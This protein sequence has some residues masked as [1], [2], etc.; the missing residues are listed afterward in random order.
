MAFAHGNTYTVAC[1]CYLLTKWISC[2]FRP[3][4]IV[5]DPEL[6]EIFCMLYAPIEVPSASTISYD[7]REIFS[8]SKSS[9]KQLLQVCDMFP[10]PM[11]A[12]GPGCIYK[13]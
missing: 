12:P 9:V 13:Y 7:I 2:R 1:M 5:E 8:M 4:M 11:T 6:M 10:T 3:F